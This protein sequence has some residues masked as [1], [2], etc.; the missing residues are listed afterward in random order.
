MTTA[1]ITG[2]NRGI[3]LAIARQLG[4]QGM[5]VVLGAR[6]AAAGEA[7]AAALRAEGL[8]ASADHLTWRRR[9]RLLPAPAR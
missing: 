9:P 5:T 8:D 7:A 3:G 6:D 4:K 1:L 2:A